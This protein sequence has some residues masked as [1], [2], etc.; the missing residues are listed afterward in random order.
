MV[1]TGSS[2]RSIEVAIEGDASSLRNAV[3]QSREGLDNLRGSAKLAGG[4][5]AALSAGAI[6]KSIQS[7]SELESKFA[8]VTTLMDG[9]RDAAEEFGDEVARLSSEF[10]VTGG[11]TE[12]VNAL[13]DILSASFNDTSEATTV[14][15]ESLKSARAGLAEASTTA[16]LLTTILNGYGMEA[17]EAS[18]VS[19]VLFQTIESGKTRMSELAGSLGRVVPTASEMGVGIE[20]V[21]AAVATLTA[22]GQSTSEATTALNRVLTN[23]LKPTGD[24]ADVIDRMGYESGRALVEQEGLAGSLEAVSEHAEN[25]ED[26]L[27]DVFSNVRALR[28]ALPLANE[29]SEDFQENLDAMEESAGAA[30]EAFQEVSDTTRFQF[31][32]TLNSLRSEMT[33]TGETFLPTVTD[34]LRGVEDLVGGFRRL[35]KASDGAA[36]QLT[37]LAGVAAGV[38]IVFGSTAGVIAAA[39]AA[40]VTAWGSDMANIK[41]ITQRTFSDIAEI[42]E[43]TFPRVTEALRLEGSEQLSILD[44]LKL[45]FMETYDTL[46]SGL[47]TFVDLLLTSFDVTKGAIGDM[48]DIVDEAKKGNFDAAKQIAEETASNA[49]TQFNKFNERRQNRSRRLRGRRERRRL[50][51]A[52]FLDGGDDSGSSGGGTGGSAASGGDTQEQ[53]DQIVDAYENQQQNTTEDITDILDDIRQE[54]RRTADAT[55]GTF[56]GGPCE[57]KEFLLDPDERAQRPQQT[58][59]QPMSGSGEGQR[60]RADAEL[61]REAEKI[62]SGQSMSRSENRSRSRADAEL[63]REAEKIDSG[64]DSATVELNVDGRKLAE[65]NLRA[66]RKFVKSTK[67]T[68]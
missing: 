37:L 34:M 41:T 57:L 55:E 25:S 16:D 51:L 49:E 30:D 32:Q 29:A 2:S 18:R 66:A 31:Q 63:F 5:L 53:I 22:R 59:G 3:A 67:V 48:V 35:N 6:A 46:S 54:N 33:R 1:F 64:G 24:A 50:K 11:Q 65:E 47:V 39:G 52:G 68:E 9:N 36:G 7:A 17:S 15:E 4:A 43:R 12:T 38:G 40:A 19:D 10:A 23:L 56:G 21:S 8:E 27:D 60:H 42:T 26:S 58:G 61:F 20:E 44:K 62:D 14:L 13:Y 28:G 45:G